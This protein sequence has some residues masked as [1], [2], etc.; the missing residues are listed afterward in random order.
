MNKKLNIIISLM[1]AITLASLM[2][3][4]IPECSATQ[5]TQYNYEP[6]FLYV[7][8]SVSASVWGDYNT[9]GNFYYCRFQ[10]VRN[11]GSADGFDGLLW[12]FWTV[13]SVTNEAGID[14]TNKDESGSCNTNYLKA[15]TRSGFYDLGL[16]FSWYRDTTTVPITPS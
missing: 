13:G 11:Y 5:K 4:L 2:L 16:G 1:T 12:V 6:K 14:T 3:T 8:E 7:G 10:S 15:R 9:G